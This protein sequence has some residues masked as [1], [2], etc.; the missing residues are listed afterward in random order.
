MIMRK[1]SRDGIDCEAKYHLRIK[2]QALKFEF[3]H[4]RQLPATGLRRNN[5]VLFTYL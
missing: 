2:P 1:S 4:P 3:R 5:A